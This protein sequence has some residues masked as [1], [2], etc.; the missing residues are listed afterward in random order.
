MAWSG[1][2]WMWARPKNAAE[3]ACL[4][5]RFWD[6]LG[7]VNR[8]KFPKLCRCLNLLRGEK[9]ERLQRHFMI[10]MQAHVREPDCAHVPIASVKVA[11]ELKLKLVRRVGHHP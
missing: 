6:Q 8:R 3:V 1:L 2:S 4:P 5:R 9:I 10:F 11:H 7:V